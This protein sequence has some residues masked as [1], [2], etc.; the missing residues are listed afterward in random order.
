[1]CV[2]LGA[3][4]PVSACRRQPR[5]RLVI[6]QTSPLLE[7]AARQIASRLEQRGYRVD[8][9]TGPEASAGLTDAL[10]LNVAGAGSGMK[11]ESFEIHPIRSNGFVLLRVTGADPRA[12]FWGALE[13]ADQMVDGGG[14][15][16][17]HSA[18]GSA[19]LSIRASQIALPPAG[20]PKAPLNTVREQLR[21]Y[22]DLLAQNRFNSVFLE[23]RESLLRDAQL[24]RGPSGSS[25]AE[26]EKAT[27]EWNH[28]V[29]R[30]ARDY[31]LSPYLELDRSAFA[32]LLSNLPP[33][34]QTAGPGLAVAPN[35]RSALPGVL[36]SLL[37]TYPELGGVALSADV[38]DLAGP[39]ERRAGWLV[40]NLL[41]PL[42]E[43]N[44][45]RPVFI[46][47]DGEWWPSLSA[48]GTISSQVPIYLLAPIQK[49]DHAP[50][51]L[52]LPVLWQVEN[53]PEELRPWQDP[54][55]VR[56]S[57]L[58]IAARS[59]LG[60]LDPY[61]SSAPYPGT[62]GDSSLAGLPPIEENWFRTMLWGRLGYSPELSG[63]Y[64]EEQ[65]ASRFP[66]GSGK[67]A[68]SA[69]IHSSQILALLHSSSSGGSSPAG[70]GPM[71]S[72]P[73]GES[74]NFEQSI[75][76]PVSVASH[77]DPVTDALSEQG[78]LVEEDHGGVGSLALADAF[79]R[80]ARQALEASNAAAGRGA[81][82]GA[83]HEEFRRRIESIARTGHIVADTVRAGQ[84][85]A[86]FALGGGE[87]L[88]LQALRLLE[89]AQK[90]LGKN[91][92]EDER[93]SI[94]AAETLAELRSRVTNAME[95]G[96]QLQPWRWEQTNWELGVREAWQPASA[97][98]VPL[99]QESR[100]AATSH[101]VEFGLYGRQPW[102]SS[103]N[104]RLRTAF[105]PTD[106]AG[107][108]IP[109]SFLVGKTAIAA[110]RDG[111]L[112]LRVISDEPCSVWVDRRRA[113]RVPPQQFSWISGFAPT[114][115]FQAQL[116][117]APIQ[118]GNNEVLVAATARQSWPRIAVSFLLPPDKNDI[119]AIAPR[120]T[121][122]LEGGV[123]LTPGSEAS[124][125]PFIGLAERERGEPPLTDRQ[126]LA[127]YRFGIRDA[128]LYRLR[129]WF[130]WRNGASAGLTLTLDGSV[131]KRDFGRGDGNYQMWHWLPLEGVAD[132]GPGEHSLAISG[133]KPG[134]LLGTVELY[135][136][137]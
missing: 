126:P 75:F 77:R 96:R 67:L 54:N 94:L 5:L 8:I 135:P 3:L 66:N 16:A 48:F 70:S 49:L 88:R 105:L 84:L 1:M 134:A 58:R 50:S 24:D 118:T 42:A 76:R 17:T 9:S 90:A 59:S 98:D 55:S 108:P 120:E 11:P 35:T 92:G 33:L 20:S 46:G 121:I 39:A 111:R 52:D 4:L 112:V 36:P 80:E 106:A 123:V 53:G 122:H 85:L 82:Q 44:E 124:P 86:R 81:W 128:G 137:W 51:V 64:W 57:L 114:S 34:A 47:V 100:R 117:S 101:L 12:T 136:A 72:V 89:Q 129:L 119:V 133:W 14:L 127:L 69:A 93:F 21:Q 23:S 71:R 18:S 32:E 61:R 83:D 87:D 115:P 97:T 99:P 109:G 103:I 116:F 27:I 62:S 15:E 2:L 38:E 41:S 104:Q 113:M 13:A 65:F 37:R 79:E 22:F 30:M 73:A 125:Q 26:V 7:T 95:F 78:L 107:N 102:M 110:R 31:G 56:E 132:L 19:F 40:E 60:F 45:R 10:I 63:N 6:Q 25:P 130:L 43:K 28:E 74:L 29:F 131:L 91:A 68:A